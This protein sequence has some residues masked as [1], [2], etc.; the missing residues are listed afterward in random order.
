MSTSPAKVAANQTNAQSSTGPRTP[1]G[2]SAVSQNATK[3]GLFSTRDFVLAH[4]LP[5]WAALDESIRADLRPT[6][7]IE[8][9]VVNEIRSA[10][11]R[12]R[13]CGEI[14]AESECLLDGAA[15]QSVDRARAQSNR[16]LH[17]CLA[18]LRALQTQRQL[19]L[20]YFD[21][22]PPH[23][24]P[25]L[26]DWRTVYKGLIDKSNAILR[27]SQIQRRRE[28]ALLDRCFAASAEPPFTK[29][30]HTPAPPMPR[31]AP[32]PCGSGLKAKRCCARAAPPA[33]S[34]AA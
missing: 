9:A 10:L 20:E 12:L 26:C 23:T 7:P 1:E 11:W 19:R 24:G 13:R 16:I 34:E 27:E 8:E 33:L 30:T 2:K 28:S 22:K 17:R 14:E 31:N 15:Q 21:G 29:Q 18:E 4:E 6:G 32:C 25:G 5:V 3:S